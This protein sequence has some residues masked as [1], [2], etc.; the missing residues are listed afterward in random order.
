MAR[1]SKASQDLIKGLRRSNIAPELK[2]EWYLAILRATIK[3][4]PA[5]ANAVLKDAVASLNQ[6]KEGQPFDTTEVFRPLGAPL[7]DMDEFVVKDA[8]ASVTSVRTRTHL[9]LALLAATF[10]RLKSTSRN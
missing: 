10:Q 7:L 9:R 8:L 6:L 4:Q 3:Y 1:R 5:D 2:S